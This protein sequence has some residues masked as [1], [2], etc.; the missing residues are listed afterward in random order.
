MAGHNHHYERIIVDGLTY[1]V[2]GLGGKNIYGIGPKKA[3]SQS[4]Y[5]G[6]YGAMLLEA[7]ANTLSLKFITRSGV[8]VDATTLI[9]TVLPVTLSS[10]Q[11]TRRGNEAVLQWATANELRNRG[12]GIE[13]SMDGSAYRTLAFL[14]ASG[15]TTQQPQHY[16]YRDAELNKSGMRYYRLRQEDEDGKHTYYGPVPVRFDAVAVALSTYP[17][18]FE[19][20]LTLEIQSEASAAATITL[21]DNLGRVVWQGIRTV[22]PGSNRVQLVPG[23]S[24]GL[25]QATVLLNS[26]VISQRVVKR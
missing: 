20:E 7:S 11:A 9:R 24:K 6:D 21:T 19:E 10:F 26:K 14:P 1:I 18:P 16:Q 22:Q 17:N 2:N 15:G 25:Y 13:V 5:A 12:F 23:L 3:Y 4:L 8:E